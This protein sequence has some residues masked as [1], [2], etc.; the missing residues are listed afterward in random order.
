MNLD[1]STGICADG[2]T[3]CVGLSDCSANGQHDCNG[4]EVCL[5]E[6]CCATPVCLPLSATCPS[7]GITSLGVESSS[8][9]GPTIG[10]SN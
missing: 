6:T 7:T 3:Q 5:L 2:N 10:G 4:D 1:A 9:S 8:S